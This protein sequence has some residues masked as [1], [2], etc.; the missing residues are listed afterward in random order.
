VGFTTGQLGLW[1]RGEEVLTVRFKSV[2]VV[3][4]R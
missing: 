1:R 2:F 4:R 3:G